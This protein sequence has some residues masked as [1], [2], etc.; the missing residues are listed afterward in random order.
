V[1]ILNL[2]QAGTDGIG[3]QLHGEDGVAHGGLVEEVVDR[4]CGRFS[5]RCGC[6]LGSSMRAN[7]RGCAFDGK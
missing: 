2:L 4:H 7:L 3:L 1:R 6:R 5:R